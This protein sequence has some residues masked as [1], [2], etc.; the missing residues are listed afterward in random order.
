MDNF[1]AIIVL[2]CFCDDCFLSLPEWACH[3]P[4]LLCA[5]WPSEVQRTN[6]HPFSDFFISDLGPDLLVPKLEL[7]DVVGCCG[8]IV[9][10]CG[11]FGQALLSVPVPVLLAKPHW[12]AMA[13]YPLC[14][15]APKPSANMWSPEHSNHYWIWSRE[16]PPVASSPGSWC[17]FTKSLS[18]SISFFLTLVLAV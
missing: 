1:P 4:R 7:W 17:R 5:R 8:I 2:A 13:S 9:G 15:S 16:W 12:R 3:P 6:G 10:Y 14:G 18:T 11:F